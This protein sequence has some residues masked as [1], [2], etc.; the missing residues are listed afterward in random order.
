M[1]SKNALNDF[2]KKEFPQ[3]NCTVIAVNDRSSEIKYVVDESDLRP[4]GTVSGPSMMKV[5]DVALYVAVLGAK[6]LIPLAVTTN[7]NIN[8][9]NKPQAHQD[10]IAKCELLKI[11][12]VLVVGQITL[13]SEGD[14]HP[15]AHATGTYSIPPNR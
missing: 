9:L 13:F 11:G 6:G 12:K 2:L 10:I 14:D 4:G 3:S 1:V 5:A 15:I 8:F 7:M